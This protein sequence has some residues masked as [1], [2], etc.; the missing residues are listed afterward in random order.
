MCVFL[1]GTIKLVTCMYLKKFFFFLSF[2]D[3]EIVCV[4]V[5]IVIQCHIYLNYYNNNMADNNNILVIT[6]VRCCCYYFE[7]PIVTMFRSA[8]SCL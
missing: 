4:C 3:F 5:L 6:C 8:K 2:K 1:Y 7:K